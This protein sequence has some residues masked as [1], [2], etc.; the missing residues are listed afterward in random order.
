MQVVVGAVSEPAMMFLEPV[1]WV[2]PTSAFKPLAAE[3][4]AC[5]FHGGGQSRWSII[6]AMPSATF[7]RSASAPGAAEDLRKFLS[8]RPDRVAPDL[9]FCGGVAGFIGYEAAALFEPGLH[10][11][12]SPYDMPDISLA[13]FDAVALFDHVAR[14]ALVVGSSR[15]CVKVL[16]DRLGRSACALIPLPSAAVSTSDSEAHYRKKVEYAIEDILNGEYYQAN[17][18]RKF[19]CDFETAPD[20]LSI[21]IALTNNSDAPYAAFIKTPTGALISNSPERFFRVEAQSGERKLT[22]EPIKGTRPRGRNAVEDGELKE[23]LAKD[24]KERA[25]NIMIADL[26]RN[27]FSRLCH[28]HSIREE[29]ICEVLTL[30]AVHHLVSRISGCLR[31]DIASFDILRALFPCGS[32]TGAPKLAAMNAIARLEAVGRGPYCGAI[33]YFSDCGN[34]DFSVAIRT[35]ILADKRLTAP[36]GGG[37]T[38]RSVPQA[39]YFETLVKASS[40]LRAIGVKADLS[41]AIA[42]R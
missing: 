12:P 9:P 40:T 14:R 25:E 23:A 34:A 30:N 29:A 24:P 36:A 13:S 17:L 8:D 35:L 11:P 20:P 7:N 32:I 3:P 26:M 6:A 19:V 15:P 10:L 37:I 31:N 42:N 28:D 2:D 41:N 18:S 39:E 22:A 33:G 27:D 5:L 16:R 21:F 38:L 1:E 4:F